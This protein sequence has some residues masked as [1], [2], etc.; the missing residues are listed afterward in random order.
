[1]EFVK[2]EQNKNLKKCVQN[3]YVEFEDCFNL[4]RLVNCTL[5]CYDNFDVNDK[6]NNNL[7]NYIMFTTH[8]FIPT[9]KKNLYKIEFWNHNEPL[10][11]DYLNDEYKILL[12][13]PYA[14]NFYFTENKENISRGYGDFWYKNYLNQYGI[15]RFMCGQWCNAFDHLLDMNNCDD[16]IILNCWK[17]MLVKYFKEFEINEK[18]LD[19]VILEL[20]KNNIEKL[21][22]EKI[23]IDENGKKF[24]ESFQ[25]ND[26][27]TYYID[28]NNLNIYSYAGNDKWLNVN[29][30]KYYFSLLMSYDNRF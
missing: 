7:K 29:S 10:H 1:M 23:I 5:F 21:F 16:L 25:T 8:V 4:N 6:M 13:C 12:H 2:I 24:I 11:L 26:N 22:K 19:D 15:I 20:D 30:G 14:K 17:T 18:N 3:F 27:C 9:E 28:K